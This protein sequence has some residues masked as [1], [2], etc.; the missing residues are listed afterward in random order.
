MPPSAS[1]CQRILKTAAEKEK[2]PDPAISCGFSSLRRGGDSRVRT[3][4]LLNAIQALSQL[5]YTPISDFLIIA[6]TLLNC[7]QKIKSI[8]K[9][10]LRYSSLKKASLS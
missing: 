8:I 1:F 3:D 5:S 9:T 6:Q 2:S 4:D 7:K 10:L